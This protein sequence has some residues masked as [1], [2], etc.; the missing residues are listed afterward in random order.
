MLYEEYLNEAD[1][2]WTEDYNTT[3]DALIEPCSSHARIIMIHSNCRKLLF[4]E[5]VELKKNIEQVER[6]TEVKINGA[7]FSLKLKLRW[8]NACYKA[9]FQWRNWYGFV[10][11]TSIKP[12]QGRVERCYDNEIDLL[13]ANYLVPRVQ[14]D[15]ARSMCIVSSSSTRMHDMH[16]YNHDIFLTESGTW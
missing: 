11:Q 15:E 3:N 4:N 9:S 12:P 13:L 14:Y 1:S 16:Q 6:K 5:V 7:T 10:S 8:E 2:K